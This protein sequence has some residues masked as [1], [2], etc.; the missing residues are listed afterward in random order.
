MSA[1]RLVYRG[2]LVAPVL[3]VLAYIVYG[4]SQEPLTF[5]G[6][7]AIFKTA[8]LFL[9]VMVALFGYVAL[10]NYLGRKMT[11]AD[12]DRR[13]PKDERNMDERRR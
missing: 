5:P 13:K 10:T 1:W 6:W 11:E 4:F 12:N 9:C 8:G 3:A 7:P 2:V